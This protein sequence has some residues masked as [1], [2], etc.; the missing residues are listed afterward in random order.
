V[1]ERK[2]NNYYGFYGFT[3]HRSTTPSFHVDGPPASPEREQ[4]RA[5]TNWLLLKASSSQSVEE[6]LRRVLWVEDMENT[7]R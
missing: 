7:V 1:K 3:S 2:K 5:G 6:I 4:W